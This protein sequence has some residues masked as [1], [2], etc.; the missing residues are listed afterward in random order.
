MYEAITRQVRVQVVPRFLPE[1]SNPRQKIFFWAY[2]IEIENLSSTTI[3]LL[4]RHWVITDSSGSVQEVRGEGVVGDQPVL[5][6][7]ER[8]SYTSGCP[9][10][11]PDGTMHGTYGMIDHDETT[12]E[13]KIPLFALDSPHVKKTLH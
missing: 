9:L 2:T 7:G 1:E 5:G 11:T 10:T 6:P 12:F 13:V 3:Q 4:T 8:F